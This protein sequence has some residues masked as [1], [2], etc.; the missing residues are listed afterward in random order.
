[1]IIPCLVAQFWFPVVVALLKT[2]SPLMSLNILTFSFSSSITHPVYSKLKLLALLPWQGNYHKDDCY[3]DGI[4]FVQI[5][6]P[7]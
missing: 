5:E 4:P 6:N 3:E 1:M 2:F 7:Y